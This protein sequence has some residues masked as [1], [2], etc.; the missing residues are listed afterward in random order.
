MRYFDSDKNEITEAEYN[1]RV[2]AGKKF[3]TWKINKQSAM[4]QYSDSR[5]SAREIEEANAPIPDSKATLIWKKVMIRSD[6]N[7]PR[8]MEDLITNN[9]SLVI[10]AEMK[11]RYDDK[12]KIR[13]EKP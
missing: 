5:Q 10:P 1:I 12:I 13:A 8:H 11:K 6:K 9:A 3:G 4:K 2:S 7:M